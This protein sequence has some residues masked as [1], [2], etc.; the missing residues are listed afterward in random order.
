MRFGQRILAALSLALGSFLCVAAGAQQTPPADLT[1]E[2]SPF[3][4]PKPGQSPDAAAPA[5]PQGLSLGVLDWAPIASRCTFF[6]AK[7]GPAELAVAPADDGGDD[8]HRPF[9]FVT[10]TETGTAGGSPLE[11]GYVMANGLVRELEKGKTAADKDGRVV[12]VWR[13]ASEPR[14]NVN[15]MLQSAQKMDTALEY[16]GSMT[17]FWGDKKVEVPIRGSCD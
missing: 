8:T 5:T 4:Q 12:T 11:R 3:A 14:I 6:A 15:L 10:M 2:S 17:V 7:G 1:P 16:A 9:V 13:S